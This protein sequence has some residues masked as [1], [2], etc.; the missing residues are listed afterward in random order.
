M[1]GHNKTGSIKAP[2]H[3]QDVAPLPCHAVV[4][5]HHP[6]IGTT[7]TLEDRHH[8]EEEAEGVMQEEEVEEVEGVM[9]DL[10]ILPTGE[11]ELAD[12]HLDFTILPR[13]TG[14][15]A[16]IIRILTR[17]HGRGAIVI[18]MARGIEGIPEKI[19]IGVK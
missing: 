16:V 5:G 12:H 9:E 14:G 17:I 2:C 7:E 19:E 10:T 4:I 13:S 11:E 15:L 3:I 8:L 6:M 18:L 1:T